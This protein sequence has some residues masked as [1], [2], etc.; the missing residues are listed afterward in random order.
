MVS[1][2]RDDLLRTLLG[3]ESGSSDIQLG[4]DSI[5][6]V[7]SWFDA[8]ARSGMELAIVP[9]SIPSVNNPVRWFST[10]ALTSQAYRITR[11]DNPQTTATKSSHHLAALQDP[12]PKTG[13]GTLTEHGSRLVMP[14]RENLLHLESLVD[15]TTLLLE[16]KKN[17]DRVESR[18][19]RL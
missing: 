16:T 3:I 17:V 9:P 8:R 6:L 15:L 2:S 12:D 13:C 18:G 5:E 19:L 1:N 4:D 7:S 10:L 14:T 11:I